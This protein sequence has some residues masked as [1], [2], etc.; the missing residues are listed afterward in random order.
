LSESTTNYADKRIDRAAALKTP[1][2]ER[3]EV[4]GESVGGISLC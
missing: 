1:S 4:T 2:T 3:G